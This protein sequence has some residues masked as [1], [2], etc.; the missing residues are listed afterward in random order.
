MDDIVDDEDRHDEDERAD[1]PPKPGHWR[2]DLLFTRFNTS[3]YGLAHI[4]GY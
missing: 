1:D 4:L 3:I 2:E